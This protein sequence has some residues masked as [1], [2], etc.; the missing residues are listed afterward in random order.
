MRKIDPS[1]TVII[2]PIL[3]L[4]LATFIVIVRRMAP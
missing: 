1:V 3:T 4:R 2:P